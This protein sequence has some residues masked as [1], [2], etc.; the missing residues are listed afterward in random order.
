MRPYYQP[1]ARR[2][3]QRPLRRCCLAVYIDHAWGANEEPVAVDGNV[4]KEIASSD[5]CDDA[6]AGRSNLEQS[7]GIHRRL[8]TERLEYW[9]HVADAPTI[10]QSPLTSTLIAKSLDSPSPPLIY[11]R[12]F[13]DLRHPDTVRIGLKPKLRHHSDR[14][15]GNGDDDAIDGDGLANQREAG[16]M[17]GRQSLVHGRL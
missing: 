11:G 6:L 13:E 14:H 10:S 12:G 8:Q 9:Q 2:C 5:G 3:T 17:N 4:A 16:K 15:I 1:V 7:V